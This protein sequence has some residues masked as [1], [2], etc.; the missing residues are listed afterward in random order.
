MQ[1]QNPFRAGR[2]NTVLHEAIA[3][4]LRETANTSPLITVSY[5]DLST[6]GTL[7]RVYC[8]IFPERE[9][10]KAFAFLK[11]KEGVCKAYLKKYTTLRITPTIRFLPIKNNIV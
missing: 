9:Q 6:S 11:R 8:S 1:Q 4:F 7:A 10:K 5:V 2:T 3:S